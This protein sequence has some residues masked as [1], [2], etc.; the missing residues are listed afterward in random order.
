MTLYQMLEAV[1]RVVY[2][3]LAVLGVAFLFILAKTIR[4]WRGGR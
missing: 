3:I 2:A 4:R 1:V